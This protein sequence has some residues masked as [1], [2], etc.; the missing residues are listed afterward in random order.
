MKKN[1]KIIISLLSLF[2]LF[3]FT[4]IQANDFEANEDYY[5]Q[6]CSNPETA[7]M[8]KSTSIKVK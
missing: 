4:T 1:N 5:K 3:N 7:Q 2:L 8:L 6:L